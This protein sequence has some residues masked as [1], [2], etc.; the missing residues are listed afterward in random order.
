MPGV[1]DVHVGVGY[2]VLVHPSHQQDL[3]CKHVI[4]FQN[5]TPSPTASHFLSNSYGD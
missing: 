3:Q 5:L 1:V 2:E 4:N